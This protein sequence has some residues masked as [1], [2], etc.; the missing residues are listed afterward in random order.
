MECLVG[1]RLTFF[2]IS[3]LNLK[4]SPVSPNPSC[5]PAHS[6]GIGSRSKHAAYV[7][8]EHTCSHLEYHATCFK[9][10]SGQSIVIAHCIDALSGDRIS[11]ESD[12]PGYGRESC[13]EWSE[14]P[15]ATA[16]ECLGYPEPKQS[17]FIVAPTYGHIGGSSCGNDLASCYIHIS[18]FW[19]TDT[20]HC[21]LSNG[22][23]PRSSK[24]Y[25]YTCRN[26]CWTTASCTC[27]YNHSYDTIAG[28]RHLAS[29]SCSL[30]AAFRSYHR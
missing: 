26:H 27:N 22:F 16:F 25:S 1:A 13:D 3:G 5:I 6:N 30:Q 21:W 24:L 10:S 11:Y 23:R 17:G 20:D 2:Y 15:L 12:S 14:P 19:A 28:G 4:F 8:S 7:E 18:F 29:C 9:R